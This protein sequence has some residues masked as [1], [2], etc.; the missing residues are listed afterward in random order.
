MDEITFVAVALGIL[1]S[2]KDEAFQTLQTLLK[3]FKIK[4]FCTDDWGAYSRH[5]PGE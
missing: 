4:V 3:P 2:R 1:T 5:I